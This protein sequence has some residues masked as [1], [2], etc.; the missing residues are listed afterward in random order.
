MNSVEIL[1]L[2]AT[3]LVLVSFLCKGEKSIRTINICGAALFVVYGLALDALSVWLLNGVLVIVHLWY[4][5]R[6]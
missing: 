1:G 6:K 2:L 3:V 4:L 5:S